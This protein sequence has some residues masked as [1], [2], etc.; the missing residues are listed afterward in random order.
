M[1]VSS[2]IA[3]L[4]AAGGQRLCDVSRLIEFVSNAP[5]QELVDLV[6]RVV[7]DPLEHVL[8]VDLRIK[9]QGCSEQTLSSSRMRERHSRRCS[10]PNLARRRRCDPPTNDEFDRS[11]DE[12]GVRSAVA[13]PDRS[14]RGNY[15]A[16]GRRGDV[17]HALLR[18]H[19]LVPGVDVL[20][21][22][23]LIR[24][25][26]ADADDPGLLSIVGVRLR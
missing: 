12:K 20:R 4:K 14:C 10:R 3:L 13:N 26:P 7:G 9:S 18:M 2:T 22:I 6:D 11:L 25:M 21:L 17:Y 19:E 8:R 1:T 24:P 15:P 16:S 5:G 23:A